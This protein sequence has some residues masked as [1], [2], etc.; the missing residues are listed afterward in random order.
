VESLPICICQWSSPSIVEL[1][2]KTR[3]DSPATPTAASYRA[4]GVGWVHSALTMGRIRIGIAEWAVFTPDTGG[5]IGK[6]GSIT[7]GQNAGPGRRTRRRQSGVCSG[8]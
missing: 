7:L 2:E 3:R 4:T 1:Y 5:R 8:D 6:N